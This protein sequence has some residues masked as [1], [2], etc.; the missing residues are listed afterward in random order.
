MLGFRLAIGVAT[1]AEQ[2]LTSRR[3]SVGL[4]IN[5]KFVP[6]VE[7][8]TIDVLNPSTDKKIAVVSEAGAQDIDIAV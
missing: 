5:N 2:W 6:G 3:V 1:G 8:R 4:F 7:G